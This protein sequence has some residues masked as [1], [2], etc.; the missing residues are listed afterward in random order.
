MNWNPKD[1]NCNENH[2]VELRPIFISDSIGFCT[3]FLGWWLRVLP[4]LLL[5]VLEKKPRQGQLLFVLLALRK[6]ELELSDGI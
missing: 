1:I 4:N 5:L 3:A 2:G 6:Q